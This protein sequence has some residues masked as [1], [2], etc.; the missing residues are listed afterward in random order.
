[1]TVEELK[2]RQCWTLEQKI[3]HAVGTVEFFLSQTGRKGYVSFS[4]GK[5]STVMLDI[6]SRFVDK[7]ITTVFCNTGNE[8]PEN[9]SKVFTFT[10]DVKMAVQ[11]DEIIKMRF[12]KLRRG[13]ITRII[14][15]NPII[16][17][18]IFLSR[19]HNLQ[20]DCTLYQGATNCLYRPEIR[21]YSVC[22]SYFPCK[23]NRPVFCPHFPC[24]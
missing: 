6:I 24:I 2:Y 4:G 11:A 8:F 12:S 7:D 1:M 9:Q 14:F 21:N 10:P 22:R 19:F 16:C 23:A 17:Q 20:P 3:D 13:R 15:R 5:D 18:S